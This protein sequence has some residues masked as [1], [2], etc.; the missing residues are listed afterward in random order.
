M[1]TFHDKMERAL[2]HGLNAQRVASD[3][4]LAGFYAEAADWWWAYARDDHEEM[5]KQTRQLRLFKVSEQ[6]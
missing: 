3:V 2:N 6:Y 1:M 4:V 5:Q